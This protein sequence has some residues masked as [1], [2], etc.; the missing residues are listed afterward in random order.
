MVEN[1]YCWFNNA[2]LWVCDAYDHG[3]MCRQCTTVDDPLMQKIV[4]RLM[5]LEEIGVDESPGRH[6]YKLT[7]EL[8][9][10]VAAVWAS[11][12]SRPTMAVQNRFGTSHR[13]ATRWVTLARERQFLPPS[14]RAH[15][16]S[17]SSSYGNEDIASD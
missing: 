14:E 5:L 7:D 9:K 6:R 16:R 11:N 12:A 2:Q 8:L 10:E 3:P 13:N 1:L 15:L 17:N 4:E